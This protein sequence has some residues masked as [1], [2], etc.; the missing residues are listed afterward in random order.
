MKLQSLPLDDADDFERALLQAAAAQPV[1]HG[2]RLRVARGLGLVMADSPT[3]PEADAS[4]EGVSAATSSGVSVVRSPSSVAWSR[5]LWSGVVSGVLFGGPAPGG[6]RG[7]DAET[8]VHETRARLEGVEASLAPAV[9]SLGPAQGRPFQAE[10]REALATAAAVPH[11]ALAPAP[12]SRGAARSVANAPP[13]KPDHPRGAGE[14]LAEVKR[15]D[16][17]RAAL[18]IR[19]AALALHVLD[20]HAHDFPSGELALEA[21]VLRVQALRELSRHAEARALARRI[22]TMPGSQRYHGELARWLT[23]AP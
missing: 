17:V 16:Q 11:G 15:L 10:P 9:P 7:L 2:S 8:R 22:L 20:S 23:Q 14:L 21:A 13:S 19:Q 3:G 5:L 6:E 4:S 1:P 18:R 12:R